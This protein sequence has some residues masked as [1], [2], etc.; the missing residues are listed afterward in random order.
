MKKI[1]A[2]L[3]CILMI[4]SLASCIIIHPNTP[5][6]TEGTGTSAPEITYPHSDM[7]L[8]AS[9]A[10]IATSGDFAADVSLFRYVFLGTY[11]NYLSNYYY[12]L[13]Y[14]NLDTS[15][16]LHD[17]NYFGEEDGE[18]WYEYF[19]G[20][21]KTEFERYMR[22]YIE[23]TNAGMKLSEQDKKDLDEHMESLEAYA[24]SYDM[25]TEEYLTESYGEGMTP[26]LY[27][28]ALEFQVLGYNYYMKLYKDY[29]VT[30]EMIREAYEAD[31]KSFDYV[32]YMAVKI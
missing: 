22:L 32:D 16:P 24:A 17:Q 25:T 8:A 5:E 15:V 7:P 23:A 13:S 12:Y 18:T 11:N 4:F 31:R 6:S 29:E 9:D 10:V 2:F 14:I 3:L 28:K 19:I 1:V 21:S 27:R 30:D 26:E 20:L